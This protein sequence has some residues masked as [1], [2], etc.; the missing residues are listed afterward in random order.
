MSL[1]DVF[2]KKN[3]EVSRLK[4]ENKILRAEIIILKKLLFGL[5][6]DKDKE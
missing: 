4:E 1:L 5:E 2:R 6:L 3:D